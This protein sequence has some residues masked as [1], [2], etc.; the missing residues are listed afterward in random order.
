MVNGKCMLKD[1]VAVV[2]SLSFPAFSLEGFLLVLL[3][4]RPLSEVSN[5]TYVRLNTNSG[6]VP[7]NG[8]WLH[9]VLHQ[10]SVKLMVSR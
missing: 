2:V 7:K 5:S 8:N 3:D 9:I 6:Q 1:M 10:F 4:A